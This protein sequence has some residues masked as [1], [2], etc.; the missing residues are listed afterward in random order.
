VR[1][2]IN[3]EREEK[4]SI[5]FI[6]VIGTAVYQQ[7]SVVFEEGGGPTTEV[8]FGMLYF[9][10]SKECN[11]FLVNNGPMEIEYKFFFHPDKN[12]SE[13]NLDDSDF[14]CTPAQAGHEMTQRLLSASPIHGIIQ[15]Y[16]QIPIKL[17]C[18]TKIPDKEHRW[19]GYLCEE[20]DK[21]HQDDND[22]QRYES[23][24][25]MLYKSTAAIK[26]DEY[27][28]F[29]KRNITE[30]NHDGEKIC[31]PISVYME[32][33]C[34]YPDL[35]LDKQS[36]NFWEC[37][38]HEQK[39]ISLRLTNKNE[40]LPFDFNFRKIPH[41]TVS[42][43]SGI[44]Q[45][46][47]SQTILVSF[48]PENY[49]N[50]SDVLVL[51]YI[52]NLYEMPVRVFGFSKTLGDKKNKH[53]ITQ[54]NY[55]TII[56]QKDVLVADEKATD[57]T[58][59]YKKG[60]PKD[61]LKMKM[62]DNRI[63]DLESDGVNREILEN[64]I[65]KYNGWE[66]LHKNKV[67][68]NQNLVNL[69]KAR[70][71]KTDG[72][73]KAM[74]RLIIDEQGDN[75]DLIGVLENDRHNK[76]D[77]PKVPMLKEPEPLWVVKPIGK[78]EPKQIGDPLE[79]KDQMYGVD[80]RP[81]KIRE[82]MLKEKS[83]PRDAMIPIEKPRNNKEAKECNLELNG[84][85]LQH[86]HVGC[87]EINFGDIFKSSEVYKTFWVRN[88]LRSSIYIKIESKEVVVLQRSYPES[89]VILPGSIE[90]FN[91][92][93]YS[94][95]VKNHDRD[96]SL[97][98]TINNKH[99]FRIKILANVTPVTVKIA[100]LPPK[101]V[102]KN[103]KSEKVETSLT[104]KALIVNNG[105]AV[106]RIRWE[107]NAKKCFD[108]EPR[109]QKIKP[110]EDNF[111]VFKFTPLDPGSKLDIEDE[112]KCI[113]ENGIP[114]TIKLSAQVPL[115]VVSIQNVPNNTLNFGLVSLGTERT[116][117]FKLKNETKNTAAFIINNPFPILKFKEDCG[118]FERDKLKEVQV[119]IKSMEE[120]PNFDETVEIYI[121]GGSKLYLRIKATIIQPEVF[122]V[123]ENFDFGEVELNEQASRPLTFQNNTGIEAKVSVQL[124]G[125]LEEFFLD[126]DPTFH[127]D[128][129]Q[130]IELPEK[131]TKEHI[132]ISEPE[133]DDEEGEMTDEE[134][135]APETPQVFTLRVLPN[136]TTHCNFFFRPNTQSVSS[137]NFEFETNFTLGSNTCK[138]LERKVLA[139]KIASS[140]FL[141]KTEIV[142]NKTFI[143]GSDKSI[144]EETI[145]MSNV[146]L[147]K[148]HWYFD[149]SELER[150]MVFKCHN[151]SG[152]L[153]A[154][155]DASACSIKFTFTPLTKR[156][157]E[158]RI[159]LNIIDEKS[160]KSVKTIKLK[161]EG[162]LPRL[163]FDQRVLILPVVPLDIESTINFKI[164]N[165]GYENSKIDHKII[166]EV[167]T[168]PLK[169]IYHDDQTI[170]YLKNTLNM[171]LSFMSSTPLSFTCKLVFFDEDQNEF[172]IMVAG[173][174]ENCIFTNFS[175][176]QRNADSY[177]YYEENDS[178]KLRKCKEVEAEGTEDNK[179]H[180]SHSIVSSSHSKNDG[181][182]GRRE[183]YESSCK[184]LKKLIRFICPNA[185]LNSTFPE[186]AIKD[187]GD[188]IYEFIT[189]LCGKVPPGKIAKLETDKRPQQLRQQYYELLKFLMNNG[190]YVSTIF[191]EYLLAFNDFKKYCEK[192]GVT[193][194]ILEQNWEK[195]NRLSSSWKRMNKE[196]WI[197]LMYQI[198]KVFYLSRVN[199]KSFPLAIRH[200]EEDIGF[201][202]NVKPGRSNVYSSSELYLIKWLQANYEKCNSNT[203][204]MIKSFDDISKDPNILASLLTAYFPKME[205]PEKKTKK[206]EKDKG[207]ITPSQVL[208]QLRN[209]G[210]YSHIQPKHLSTDLMKHMQDKRP[211]VP[212]TRDYLML[213]IM[214]FQNLQHFI[215]KDCISFSCILGEIVNKTINL[216]NPSN[217]RIEYDV[218]LEGSS[219][220]QLQGLKEVRLDPNNSI[221]YSVTF[222]SRLSQ[223]VNGR[224]YFTNK[225]NQWIGQAAPLVY[226]LTSNVTGRRSIEPPKL[227]K[228]PLYKKHE[229]KLSVKSPFKERGQ[230]EIRLYQQK[231]S[232][233]KK[234]VVNIINPKKDKKDEPVYKVF[235]L[236]NDEGDAKP[237]VLDSE[238]TRDV[239]VFFLPIDLDT[240]ECNIVFVNEKIGEFQYTIEGKGELP[241]YLEKYECECEVD[242]PAEFELKIRSS[243]AKLTTALT[244]LKLESGKINQSTKRLGLAGPMSVVSTKPYFSVPQIIYPG[245]ANESG[246]QDGEEKF[247]TTGFNNMTTNNNN[248]ASADFYLLKV[249]FQSKTCQLYE[250]EFVLT[251]LEKS[252]DIRVYKIVV[253]VKPKPIKVRLEFNCPVRETIVQKIPIYN[254]S[255]KEWTISAKLHSTSKY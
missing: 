207:Q 243:N 152:D 172:S 245:G 49:G 126:I 230:F 55:Q 51:K 235:F 159:Y 134:N 16:T 232:S 220:F 80:V 65:E 92:V 216:V 109:E 167:G 136:S 120:F 11:A 170:G 41:F 145:K 117:F 224:L 128:R 3:D 17:I 238:N 163:C 133:N 209:Y 181:R 166:A 253:N 103:D 240:Y 227:I 115:S 199:A 225:V 58:K 83:L 94:N 249:R 196:S 96:L 63:K 57:Y 75:F 8:N 108:V 27:L 98:Y 28:P 194:K 151:L 118:Y 198:M 186:V 140:V 29:H 5:G 226:I 180:V 171:E 4:R 60:V 251:N 64:Y 212:N 40:E 241:E 250:G 127:Q 39:V 89:L 87:E 252:N 12:R 223:Q 88:N 204:H 169:V 138:G 130:Y 205:E 162:T 70:E 201:K 213:T 208:I 46:K 197:L 155:T 148:L 25:P 31:Q 190:A 234:K 113:I 157:Y 62:L 242:D 146:T 210:I 228:Q 121:R 149:V 218:T 215:P 81:E 139:K 237:I 129:T 13:V 144:S 73:A 206:K 211:T 42:P 112:L 56:S 24:R 102:F 97:K 71:R 32:V 203:M 48:H 100:N 131:D 192:D 20:Y 93:F 246:R 74:D 132:S 150:D 9:G 168:I 122:I 164:I 52:N 143:Y 202:Y 229:Y 125:F 185:I 66:V 7:L 84:E 189:N 14:I 76:V 175:F 21:I 35:T 78:Y 195:S 107:E 99:T 137:K 147:G 214:L 255:D 67:E 156:V 69:R 2:T 110:G 19:K 72:K 33:K 200:I 158:S 37:K 222:K 184:F 1:Q 178:I 38:I 176:I 142:F 231:K 43:P 30:I 165:E 53:L 85:A 82:K 254:N 119:T 95:E 111:C 36:L 10:Q 188:I 191:P 183:L 114:F 23:N 182:P 101:F 18:N 54:D 177:E 236:R 233:Q 44:I 174:A 173:I 244:N 153:L 91:I 45:P 247:L 68:A 124:I 221:E 86:V 141:P 161:G 106:A 90:G 193:D 160:K 50:F 154:S 116:L 187:N 248:N 179:S 22:N 59:V 104:H 79:K 47:S 105:N 219:D 34:I 61:W 77:S 217:K 6:E 239:T 26:F 123:Q 135:N 15:P